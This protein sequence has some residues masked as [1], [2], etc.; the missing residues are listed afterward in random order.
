MKIAISKLSTLLFY[1]QT[2]TS[3]KN[4]LDETKIPVDTILY[5]ITW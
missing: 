3:N 5:F 4:C 1:L 2:K